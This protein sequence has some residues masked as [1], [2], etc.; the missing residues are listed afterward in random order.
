MD[1]DPPNNFDPPHNLDPPPNSVSYTYNGPFTFH[2]NGAFGGMQNL[3]G[4]RDIRDN[5]FGF[6]QSGGDHHNGS[7]MYPD[8]VDAHADSM[9]YPN[10]QVTSQ[11]QSHIDYSATGAQRSPTQYGTLQ[12]GYAHAPIAGYPGEFDFST[13]EN[14]E[15]TTDWLEY[16]P[17]GSRAGTW[18]DGVYRNGGSVPPPT[19]IMN[20]TAPT[21]QA[22]ED[23]KMYAHDAPQGSTFEGTSSPT[24]IFST[25]NNGQ[26]GTLQQLRPLQ[27]RDYQPLPPAASALPASLV[28]SQGQLLHGYQDDTPLAAQNFTSSP[29]HGTGSSRMQ[30]HQRPIDARALKSLRG[31][32]P[33]LSQPAAPDAEAV[34]EESNAETATGSDHDTSSGIGDAANSARSHRTLALPGIAIPALFSNNMTSAPLGVRTDTNATQP[35]AVT[36]PAT[37]RRMV[38]QAMSSSTGPMEGMRFTRASARENEYHRAP[39]NVKND[40]WQTVVQE[41]HKYVRELMAA[42]R[43][44]YQAEPD[45]KKRTP[46]SAED[47]A[48]WTRFQ[49]DHADKVN[50]IIN[51]PDFPDELELRCWNLFDRLAETHEKGCVL[52]ASALN[53]KSKLSERIQL[54]ATALSEFPILQ[55]DVL[56]QK[57]L[58]EFAAHPNGT[59]GSKI[60][61][62]LGNWR[63]KQKAAKLKVEAEAKKAEDMQEAEVDA[64]IADADTKPGGKRGRNRTPSTRVGAAYRRRMGPQQIKAHN[65]AQ[66]EARK[67]DAK[68][69]DDN[70]SE[71]EQGVDE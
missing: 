27:S 65:K 22:L 30:P 17:G 53:L 64:V 35:S 20:V 7:S 43:K 42:F 46:P 36:P 24:N 55:L 41:G 8:D 14:V 4:P 2:N 48:E 31:G 16:G 49:Q 33:S 61:N 70:E 57:R 50:I 59:K 1:Q 44:P 13:P 60:T 38:G 62:M 54:T 10:P 32:G 47:Q 26:S 25:H 21:H 3:G 23:Y 56:L 71:T 11:S 45:G 5:H 63:R 28:Y 19:Y 18:W 40:D 52:I 37:D 66:R 15:P 39:L 9:I 29:S 58:L 68:R 67:L 6:Q 34:N 69:A 51:D 12:Q